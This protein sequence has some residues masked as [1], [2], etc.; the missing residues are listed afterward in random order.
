MAE[1]WGS[2]G[3]GEVWAAGG[4][5]V[6]LWRFTAPWGPCLP[7]AGL[8]HLVAIRLLERGLESRTGRFPYSLV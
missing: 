8:V 3:K 7:N 1:F 5:M 6:A 4:G 2:Q